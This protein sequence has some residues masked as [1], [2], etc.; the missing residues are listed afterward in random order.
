MIDLAQGQAPLG[1]LLTL[2]DAAEVS[3]V[4]SVRLALVGAAVVL[5][6]SAVVRGR[7]LRL[8]AG[9]HELHDA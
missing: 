4:G 3:C 8:Q 5:L 1:A 6:A 7:T 9:V 2:R